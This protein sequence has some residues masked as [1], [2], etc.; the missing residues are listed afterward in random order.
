MASTYNKLKHSRNCWKSKTVDAKKSLRYQRKETNR[1]RKER[2]SYKRELRNAKIEV[3]N[4][5]KQRLLQPV[6]NKTD[7]VLL[8]LQLFLV[9]RIGFRAVS[10]VLSILA[11][12]LGLK[13]APCT[14]T[15][16]NWVQRLSI[17][18]MKNVLRSSDIKTDT[19]SR[20]SKFILILDASIGL[21]KGK[22]MSV[23][24]LDVDHYLHNSG[25]PA[26]QHVQ[27]IAVSV[28]D[29]WTGESIAELLEKVIAQVGNPV[30]Y[31][32]DGGTDLS[33]AVRL[34]NERGNPS[35]SI[36]DIS[37][38]IA[39]L[40]KHEY[41]NHPMFAVFTSAC[42]KASKMFKQTIL[43]C[44]APPKVSV[45]ARFMNLHRLVKWASL[46]LNHSPRGRAAKG[47]LRQKLRD[48]FDQLPQCR[49]FIN[50]FLLDAEPLMACQEILKNNGLSQKAIEDCQQISDTI[51]NLTIRAGFK[52]WLEKQRTISKKLGLDE[53]GMPIT[54]DSIESL[55]GVAKHHGTGE[56][57]DA[58]RIALRIPTLC[59]TLDRKDAEEVVKV[60]VL[61]QQEWFASCPSLTKQRRDVLAH[62]G[63]LED[64]KIDDAK[65]NIELIVGS[66]SGQKAME[67]PTKT[68]GYGN[69][70][71]P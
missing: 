70:D 31:L 24:A 7:L 12:P 19:A 34:L 46:I 9:A 54:S 57:K 64:I 40:L 21:G 27:C 43:A 5:K 10:R 6:H 48:C 17:V 35:L 44:L 47:S 2:D 37:H 67:T 13:K 66:K 53:I 52:D 33:K 55:F 56:T 58:N 49:A 65:P 1:A 39:N 28:A 50:A 25:A 15:I 30:A 23:L 36:D 45:K 61:E 11:Q 20:S 41:Q 71:S 18:K 22:I 63:S 32:K 62:A 4:L 29:T 26:L 42:G 59:G 14:Q 16:I 60:T 3:E 68:V 8:A 38:F 51:P 69:I